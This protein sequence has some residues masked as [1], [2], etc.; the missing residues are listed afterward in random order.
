[1]LLVLLAVV[2]CWLLAFGF[3]LLCPATAWHSGARNAAPRPTL[4]VLLLLAV[5]VYCCWLV[6]YT[7]RPHGTVAQ[8]TR[9]HDYG[10][11]HYCVQ[12]LTGDVH[13]Y[14]IF[15]DLHCSTIVVWLLLD[16]ICLVQAL[17]MPSLCLL[18]GLL[19]YSLRLVLWVLMVCLWC[20]YG[21]IKCCIWTHQSTNLPGHTPIK[22]TITEP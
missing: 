17:S 3:W 4:C 21:V 22:P 19:S 13:E 10:V 2:G 12:L 7:Q 15:L 8:G 6:G 14:H 11:L 20:A 1:M 16:C 18:C 9:R 5:G